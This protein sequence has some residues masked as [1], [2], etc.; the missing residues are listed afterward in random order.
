VVQNTNLFELLSALLCGLGS[1]QFQDI[2][3]A[4]DA[5]G[6]LLFNM[7]G[8]I[9]QFETEIRGMEPIPAIYRNRIAKS[10]VR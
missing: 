10:R 1:M 2:G 5:T 4:A 6:R 7:L 9:G 8:A 3:I